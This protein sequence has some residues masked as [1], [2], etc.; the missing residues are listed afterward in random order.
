VIARD[1]GIEPNTAKVRL[2]RLRRRFAKRFQS[3]VIVQYGFDDLQACLNAWRDAA[4]GGPAE[5]AA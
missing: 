4:L 2:S 1:L 5:P 3:S